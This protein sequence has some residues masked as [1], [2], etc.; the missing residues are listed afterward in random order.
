[1]A[2]PRVL[3]VY[4]KPTSFVRDDGAMLREHYDVSA[5]H[6][7]VEQASS[8]RGLL[9]LWA[10]QLRWL[11]RELPQ[12]DLVLGWFADHH[13]ALPVLL[14]RWFGVPTAVILGGMDCNWL[15]EYDYGV[16]DSRWRGPLV[17]WIVRRA[18]LLP[19]VSASLLEAEERYSKWPERRRNG[20]RVHVPAL[21]TPHPVVELGFDPGA[22][23][24]GPADRDRTVT[25]VGFID[26]ER[27]YKIKGI[28]LLLEAAR[29]LP[30]ASV[31]VVGVAPAFADRLRRRGLVPD[32]VEL[33]PPRPR[34]ALSAVYQKTSVYAQLSR[35]EAFGLVVGEAML[36]G[37]IPV[38]SPVG[39]LPRLVGDVGAVVERPDPEHIASVLTQALNGP[40]E[41]AAARRRIETRFSRTR[42][43]RRLR[44]VLETL[45]E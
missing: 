16:W 20:I 22:W 31:R 44:S 33:R 26:S 4:L 27:T 10:R 18:D 28:D 29:R 38:V 36:S 41:R 8:A 19:S 24:P 32:N 25:T 37:C 17:R 6:F 45:R 15:P 34:E 43:D 2:D 39:Q 21:G 23:P 1:M 42:R 5:F 13:M 35:V 40:A 3:F 30:A 14:A 9:T 12:A 7:D 11:L